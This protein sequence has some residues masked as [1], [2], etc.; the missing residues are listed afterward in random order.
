MKNNYL[1][2]DSNDLNVELTFVPR[3]PVAIKLILVFFCLIVIAGP[4]ILISQAEEREQG[5]IFLSAL[6]FY[7]VMYFVLGRYT[8]WNLFGEERLIVSTK[9]IN[10]QHHFG[11]FNTPWK[12]EKFNKIYLAFRKTHEIENQTYG[13]LDFITD[14]ENGVHTML[15]ST[16]IAVSEEEINVSLR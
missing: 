12:P 1:N 13:K 6:V 2:I 10:Y 4:L 11:F 16:S 14:D 5:L 15:Y 7:A 3:P 9:A 8:L